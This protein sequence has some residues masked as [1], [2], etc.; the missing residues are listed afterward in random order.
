MHRILFVPLLALLVATGAMLTTTTA[1]EKK[2]DDGYVSIFDGKSLAGWHVSTKTGHSNKSGKKSGGRWVVENGA[3][4]GSQ[5]IPGNGGII[6][7]DKK[8]KNFEVVLEMNNDFTIDSGLF[9]RSTEDAMKAV[10]WFDD[11]QVAKQS[12][13]KLYLPKDGSLSSGA[14]IEILPLTP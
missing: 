6:I 4:I 3:I 2:K 10:A 9:L 7:T 11:S 5:D 14:Y 8:Y 13:Q 1:G 12:A